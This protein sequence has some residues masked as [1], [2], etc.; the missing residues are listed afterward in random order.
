MQ[1]LRSAWPIAQDVPKQFS[2]NL[3]VHIC[4]EVSR[5]RNGRT[6]REC[7]TGLF[8]SYVVG[9]WFHMLRLEWSL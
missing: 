4:V 7:R 5:E 3:V 2:C 9:S 6:M 1:K 8:I